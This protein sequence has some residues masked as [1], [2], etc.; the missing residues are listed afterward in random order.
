MATQPLESATNGHPTN[1]NPAPEGTQRATHK[2]AH[3][4]QHKAPR[5]RAGAAWVGICITGAVLVALIIFM[6]QN[7]Q[8]VVVSFLGWQGSVPL[9]LALLIA[10]IG[11]GL[12][13][14]VIGTTRIGQLRRRISRNS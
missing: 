6:L 4:E 5:S 1:D 10:G 8:L 2:A 13:A 14:L 7:T 11:V 9:A 3:P 12:I